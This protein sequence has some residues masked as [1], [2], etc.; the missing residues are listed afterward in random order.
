M[1][2]KI[3][4]WK[5]ETSKGIFPYEWFDSEEK[6]NQKTFPEYESFYSKLKA[7]NVSKVEYDR[8]KL[9]FENSIQSGNLNNFGEYM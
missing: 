2:D 4:M 6:L 3:R 5:V 1:I 8:E 9:D 7:A